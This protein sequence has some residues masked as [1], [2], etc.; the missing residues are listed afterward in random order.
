MQKDKCNGVRNHKRKTPKKKVIW[1]TYLPLWVLSVSLFLS[2]FIDVPFEYFVNR[3]KKISNSY[4]N[5]KW[6]SN[7]TENRFN[8]HWN[9]KAK[10]REKKKCFLLTFSEWMLRLTEKKLLAHLSV[11]LGV[12]QT[13]YFELTFRWFFFLFL[14]LSRSSVNLYPRV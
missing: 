8:S 11:I 3:S 9:I 7:G 6:Q 13:I 10:M 2:Y 1:R 14:S 5:R 12:K 4:A